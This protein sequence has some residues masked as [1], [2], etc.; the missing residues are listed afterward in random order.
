MSDQLGKKELLT[1]EEM[2]DSYVHPDDSEKSGDATS[3]IATAQQSTSEA[4]DSLRP[5]P[6]V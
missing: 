2:F 3:Q 6:S 1:N 4:T 5:N